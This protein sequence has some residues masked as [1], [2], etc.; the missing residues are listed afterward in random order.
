ML[1][2]NVNHI[3]RKSI[4]HMGNTQ[5]LITTLRQNIILSISVFETK[6]NIS[7]RKYKIHDLLITIIGECYYITPYSLIRI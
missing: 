2:S 5:L 3:A 6:F 4:I 1:I 7:S